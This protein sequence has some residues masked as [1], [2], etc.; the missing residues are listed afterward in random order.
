MSE[1]KKPKPPAVSYDE[2]MKLHREVFTHEHV[3][4]FDDSKRIDSLERRLAEWDRTMSGTVEMVNRIATKKIGE[5]AVEYGSAVGHI[6]CDPKDSKAAPS[7]EPHESKRSERDAIRAKLASYSDTSQLASLA[8]Y[9]LPAVLDACDQIMKERDEARKL[10]DRHR[11]DLEREFNML[12]RHPW[13][14]PA[15][16][17]MPT[18]P[19]SHAVPLASPDWPTPSELRHA[20]KLIAHSGAP[21]DQVVYRAAER[22]E[23]M[24]KKLV[25]TRAQVRTLLAALKP[26]AEEQIGGKGCTHADS[27]SWREALREYREAGGKI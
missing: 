16:G 17:A 21:H 6:Y 15:R 5:M 20:A 12:I 8:C 2:F 14:D 19:S 22:I 25:E 23:E 3:R 9:E 10:A 24:D 18:A 4:S 1:K 13:D 26:F 11:D 27:D 7:A